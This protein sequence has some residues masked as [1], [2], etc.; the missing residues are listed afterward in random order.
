MPRALAPTVRWPQEGWAGIQ[1]SV[2]GRPSGSLGATVPSVNAFLFVFLESRWL[3][4]RN[5]STEH[6]VALVRS[7][8]VP[9]G[10]GAVSYFVQNIQNTEQEQCVFPAL[11]FG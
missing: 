3:H 6:T 5:A 2:G 7:H 4:V 8:V 11:G 10:G 1:W 9:S